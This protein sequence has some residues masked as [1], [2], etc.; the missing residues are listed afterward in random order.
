MKIE[1]TLS[2]NINIF[3]LMVFSSGTNIAEGKSATQS[4]NWKNLVASRAVD[5]RM[6]TFSHTADSSPWIEVDLGSDADVESVVIKNR[7]CRNPTDPRNCL[8]RLSQANL[9]LY[10]DSGDEITSLSVGNTCG[11][12]TLEYAFEAS[13]DYCSD[14]SRRLAVPSPTPPSA[15]STKW[16][17]RNRNLRKR[18]RKC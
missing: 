18:P 16:V 11:E 17:R 12:A 2:N 13:F 3:E 9:I 6:N 5:G 10:D 14:T 15:S 4:S 7:W 8:C 1:A